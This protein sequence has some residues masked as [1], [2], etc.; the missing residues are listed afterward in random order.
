MSAPA[1]LD[2]LPADHGKLHRHADVAAAAR[3]RPRRWRLVGEYAHREA[4]RDAASRIRRGGSP[5]WEARTGGYY[6]PKFFT[7]GDGE[8]VVYVQWIPTPKQA[9]AS[10]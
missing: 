3:A 9:G 1:W 5:A 8:H 7:N 4:A 10:R 2:K 6:H